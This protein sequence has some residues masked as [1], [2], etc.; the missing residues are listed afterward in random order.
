MIVREIEIK[1]R[2]YRV[3][4]TTFFQTEK[5]AV[6]IG[7]ETVSLPCNE[8]DNPFIYDLLDSPYKFAMPT[9]EPYREKFE[10][11]ALTGICRTLGVEFGTGVGEMSEGVFALMEVTD[12]SLRKEIDK[13]YQDEVQKELSA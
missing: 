1:G 10:A 3:G 11:L 6:T 8:H 13:M 2:P 7:F 9:H 12:E 4:F 5:L